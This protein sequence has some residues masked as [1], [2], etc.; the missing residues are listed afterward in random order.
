VKALN[1]L[2]LSRDKEKVKKRVMIAAF[3]VQLASSYLQ[4]AVTNLK[5]GKDMAGALLAA[6]KSETD[7]N[8]FC[9]P[10]SPISAKIEYV[11]AALIALLEAAHFDPSGDHT[12]ITADLDQ[13]V[14]MLRN[15]FNKARK[16]LPPKSE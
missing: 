7:L 1:A 13:A 10:E 15:E 16:D 9:Q 2:P 11:S 3:Q 8:N 5:N 6:A 14:S 4:E 12:R